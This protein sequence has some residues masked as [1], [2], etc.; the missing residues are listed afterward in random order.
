MDA[1]LVGAFVV[2]VL[3]VMCLLIQ[4]TGERNG[5]ERELQARASALTTQLAQARAAAPLAELR[6]ILAHPIDADPTAVAAEV[7]S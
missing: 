4:V 6:F 7:K 1:W 2:S 3:F 5:L